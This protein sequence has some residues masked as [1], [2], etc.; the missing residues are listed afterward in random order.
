[1]VN[2]REIE[3]KWQ[4]V[5][6]KEKVF[7]ADV[8]SSKPKF[9]ITFPYPYVNGAPHIGHGYSFLRTDAYARYKRMRGFNVLFPQGFHATGEPIVGV[10]ERLRNNDEKQIATLKKSGATDEDIERFK[11]TPENIVRFWM[12]RW[13]EDLKMVG[14]SIDWRRTFVTTTMTLQYS[15]FIEWQY[16]TLR[17]R[18][19]IKKGTHPVIW[20]PHCESPTGD[21]DRL[22]GEGESPVDY[23]LIKFRLVDEDAFLVAATLRSETVF[24]VTNIWVKEDADYVKARVNGEVW[25]I[26]KDAVPKL[27]DQLKEVEVLEEI[28]GRD[29]LGK[30]CANP[31]NGKHVPILPA[32]FVDPSN[33]TGVVMSVP[34]HAPFDYAA[35][36][37]LLKDRDKLVRYGVSADELEPI[38]LID[39]KGFGKLPA[40]EIVEKTGIRSQTEKEKLEEATR[41]LYKNEF[42]LGK[43]KETCGEFAGMK[44]SEVKEKIAEWLKERGYADVMWEC[45]GR[46]VCRCGTT[47][48]VKILKDQWFLAYSDEDWKRKVIE[49]IKRMKFYPEDVRQQFINTVEWLKDKACVRKT[50]LGTPLPW[51]KE[52]IVETLSDSTIY[53]AYYT[54]ARI[55]NERKIEAEKLTDEVFDYIFLGKGNA[56][57]VAK[58]SGLDVETLEEMRR[59]FEYFYPVDLRNSG[60]D[61]VQNHL[62]FYLMHHIAIWDGMPEKWPVAISVNGRVMVEGEKMSKSKGNIIPLRNLV[63]EFGADPV[64][65]NIVCSAEGMEEA[66]WRVENIKGYVSR[67][68]YLD[69]LVESLNAMKG[70]SVTNA[71]RYLN[72]KLQK[73]IIEVTNA[74]EEM[75]FRTAITHVLFYGVNHLK[76]YFR[77]VGC[78]ERA[79]REVVER[80]LKAVIK[81]LS[82]IAPHFSEE[83]WHRMGEST[84]IVRE[85][86]PEADE[87]LINE[88]AEVLENYLES[89]MDDINSVVRL[90]GAKPEKVKVYVASQWKRDVYALVLQ[91]KEEAMKIIGN[92]DRFAEVR[93]KAIE[94]AKNLLKKYYEL[95]KTILLQEDE[96]AILEEAREFLE[97]ELG[98]ELEVMKEED[99]SSTRASKAM[100]MKPGIEVV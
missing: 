1:M 50:G 91:K 23:V 61:L 88:K 74:Y 72:S 59:E 71:E 31:V 86:W 56:N 7:E 82:P 26:S 98:C 67:L 63:E 54:I 20:C 83:M 99:A 76:W 15:R 41:K 32:D 5:W 73:M 85:S 8:D 53:M 33:A 44:V 28:K 60:K 34:A 69:G 89:L 14:A 78:I 13:M 48:H 92:D 95:E 25:I 45:T 94:L 30:R 43:L 65:L 3:K 6:E 38:S 62:T 46:V 11:E 42:H 49:H 17:K 90:V 24:G 58:N 52:W 21:H 12:K 97:K 40:K 84:L 80:F 18:G 36:M 22:E 66:D 77:R 4:E 35:V 10:W 55:I 51:D 37:D 75:K 19:Y 16:N 87:S 27:A 79:N 39:V 68:E 81:M 70:K 47:C 57:E 2:F 64:R 100:P 9:F 93:T 29:L 96:L